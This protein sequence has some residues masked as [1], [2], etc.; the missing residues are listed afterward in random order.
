MHLV[1][2]HQSE[3]SYTFKTKCLI[4]VNTADIY[5]SVW[6]AGYTCYTSY[7][8]QHVHMLHISTVYYLHSNKL[9]TH[10]NYINK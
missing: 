7:T 3:I 8:C 6:P 2:E 5:Q 1:H 9:N 10:A 4:K